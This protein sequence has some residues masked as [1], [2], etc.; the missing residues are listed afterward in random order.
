MIE[1]VPT[2]TWYPLFRHAIEVGV[3]YIIIVAPGHFANDPTHMCNHITTL[4][5]GVYEGEYGK[6]VMCG[7]EDLRRLLNQVGYAS[8]VTFVDTHTLTHPWDLDYVI[9]A[10]KNKH[11]LRKLLPWILRRKLV[12]LKALFVMP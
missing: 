1:H 6:V 11:L 2:E 9:I 4:P 7:L 10:S 3:E 12:Q 5:S 8:V